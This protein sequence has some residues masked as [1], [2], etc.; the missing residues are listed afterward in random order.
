MRPQNAVPGNDRSSNW[1]VVPGSELLLKRLGRFHGGWIEVKD[2]VVGAGP[3]PGS[4]RRV[5]VAI[6][7]GGHPCED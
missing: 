7:G 1:L 6:E 5:A 3:N 4:G 2:R